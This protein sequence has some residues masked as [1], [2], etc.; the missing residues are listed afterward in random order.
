MMET[1]WNHLTILSDIRVDISIY[2]KTNKC[3]VVNK[4]FEMRK[5]NLVMLRKLQRT[6][7]LL[8]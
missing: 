8:I 6:P 4:Y 5:V 7:R 1:V 2:Y 3:F